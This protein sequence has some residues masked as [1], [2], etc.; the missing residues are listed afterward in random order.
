MNKCKSQPPYQVVICVHLGKILDPP[1]RDQDATC[2]LNSLEGYKNLTIM[3]AAPKIYKIWENV[4]ML[5]FLK[6]FGA[7]LCMQWIVLAFS[8]K[9]ELILTLINIS[10]KN[11]TIK[12][13]QIFYTMNILKVVLSRNVFL[14]LPK[15]QAWNGGNLHSWF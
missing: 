3:Q 7:I 6:K 14:S 13:S 11:S 2:I 5:F 1:F 8:I 15:G 4:N 9:N 12:F 10:V